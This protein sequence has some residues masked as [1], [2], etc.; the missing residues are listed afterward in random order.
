LKFIDY[1]QFQEDAQRRVSGPQEGAERSRE[2][3]RQIVA[4]MRGEPPAEAPQPAALKVV[5][6]L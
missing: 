1:R 3:L 5:G 6:Q 4:R 2:L